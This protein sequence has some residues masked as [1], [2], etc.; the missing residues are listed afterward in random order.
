MIWLVLGLV[1]FL[2]VHSFSIVAHGARTGLVARYGEGAFKGVYAIV[3]VASLMLITW[4]YGEARLDPVQLWVPP[5]WAR[6]LV[7]L[8]MV[9]VFPLLVAAYA[10]GKIRS[11][12][13]HPMLTAVKAWAFAHL[14]ANGTLADLLLFGGFLAWAVAD[15]ISLKRRPGATRSPKRGWGVGDAVAIVGGLVLYGAF[16]VWLHPLLIGV[17][18]R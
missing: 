3:S 6:H 13:G 15:R 4:G 8:L 5:T 11:A 9:P 17:S 10:P 14:I 2:G 1:G 12:V 7:W 16:F 18:V